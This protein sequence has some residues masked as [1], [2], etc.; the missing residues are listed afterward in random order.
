MKMRKG[1][2]TLKRKRERRVA[3]RISQVIKEKAMRRKESKALSLIKTMVL[4]R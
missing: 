3:I 1:D 2:S 4:R